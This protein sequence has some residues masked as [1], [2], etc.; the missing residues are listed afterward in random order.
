MLHPHALMLDI[1]VDQWRNAQALLLKSAKAARRLVVIHEHGSVLKF[2][3]TDGIEC[4]GRPAQITDPHRQARELYAANKDSVDFVVVMERDAVDQYFANVQ[5][6]WRINDDLDVFVQ[7][8]YQLMDDFPEGIV[9]SPGPA[10]NVIGLQW[11]TGMSLEEANAA[12]RAM[13]PPDTTIV[14]GVHDDQQLWSSLVLDFDSEHEITSITTVDPAAVDIHGD[15]AE[16]ADRVVSWLTS[17]GKSVSVTCV[18]D[19]AVANEFLAAPVS[20]KGALL[21]GYAASGKASFSAA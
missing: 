13:V 8:T 3:H 20:E 16:V 4:A 6:S 2:R 21:V 1:D 18:L 17:T 19:R 12:A 7:R 15:R 14:L 9:S 5:N 10:R 11:N